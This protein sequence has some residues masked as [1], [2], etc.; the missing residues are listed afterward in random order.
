VLRNYV[1]WKQNDWDQHLTM[2]EM[3]INSKPQSSTGFSPFMLNY[4]REVL[5]PLDLALRNLRMGGANPSAEDR[6]RDL[7]ENLV[8]A[9][10]N[11]REAQR[12]QSLYADR[13]RRAVLYAVGDKVLLSTKHVRIAGQ[14]AEQR[15]KLFRQWIGPFTIKEV[16]NANAYKLDLPDNMHIHP[17]INISYLK[18]YHEGAEKFPSREKTDERPMAVVTED[19]GAAEFEV[20]CIRDVRVNRARGGRREWLVKWKGWPDHESTWEPRENLVGTDFIKKF[21]EQAREEEPASVRRSSR[22]RT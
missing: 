6:L 20:E 8:R 15:K 17:T 10:N 14:S 3:A 1:N 9:Q 4:G 2:A 13:H 19:N 21:E 5:K 18:P 22:K 11:I 12:R 16:V 7:A